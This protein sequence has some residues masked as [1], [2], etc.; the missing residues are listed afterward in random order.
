MK[1]LVVHIP[2]YMWLALVPLMGLGLTE[3]LFAIPQFEDPSDVASVRKIVESYV[4]DKD[5]LSTFRVHV[6]QVFGLV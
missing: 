3:L 4:G 1:R 5:F 6:R 2:K